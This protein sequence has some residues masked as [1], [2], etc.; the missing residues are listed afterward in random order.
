MRVTQNAVAATMLA[1]LFSNRAELDKYQLQ[2]S[3]GRRITRPS[4]DPVGTDQAMQ[5]RTALARTNQYQRNGNDGL[6]WLGTADSALQSGVAILQR[7]NVLTTQAA[8]TGSTGS[9]ARASIASEVESLKTQLLGI[10]NTTYLGRPIFGG[11]TS[12]GA[13][14]AQDS[15]GAVNYVGDTGTVM[16]TV[17]ANANVQVNVNATDAF[18][19]PGSDVF[20]AFDTVL[21]DLANNPQH[22]SSDISLVKSSLDRMT[23]AQAIEG[24]AYNRINAM[25]NLAGTNSDTLTANL[26]QVEDVDVAEAYTKFSMQQVSYQASLSA[27]ANVLQLSLS[28]FLR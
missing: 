3:S 24:A 10:A 23:N 27:M 22:L 7:L 13:A 11:A 19:P 2:L 17:G 21:D 4:D 5:Y 20:A 18:G 16:R 8:N 14:Y 1:G 25:V 9:T 15:T 6:A 12:G 28:D 26:S